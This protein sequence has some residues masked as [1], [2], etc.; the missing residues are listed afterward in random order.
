MTFSGRSLPSR[1]HGDLA[2]DAGQ[3]PVHGRSKALL[4]TASIAVA[5]AAADTYVVVLALQDMMSGVGISVDALQRAAPIISGFLLGY[6]AVLP[7][8][9]RLADLVA[10]Q[11]VL[12]AC[13]GIFVVGSA[14]TALSVDLPVMVTG[15]VVQ[16]IGGGGL[17]PATLALVADLW[18]R[19]RRGT[20]LGAVSAV[21]ELGS[22][23]GPLLGAL[24][25]MV[26]DW[27]AIFWINA[28][29]GVALALVIRVLGGGSDD[30]LTHAHPLWAVATGVCAFATV[31]LLG[32]ALVAPTA[33]TSSIRWGAPFVPYAGHSAR[34]A[35]PIGIWGLMALAV[36]LLCS[37]RYWWP[38]LRRADLLGAL[39]VAVALGAVIVTFASANPEQ[40]VVGPMG[41]WLL[42]VAAVAVL[43]AWWRHRTAADPLVGVGTVVGRVRPA[44][45]CSVCVG[46]A[47][48]AIVVD[49][50][51]L[52]RLTVTDSE[53]SAALI[54]VRFLVAVPVGALLGGWLLRHTGPGT[55]AAPG[56][57]VAA[58]GLW[59]MSAWSGHA[60]DQVSSTVELV[61]VGLGIGVAI[62]PLND[63]AL[64]DAPQDAHGMA[65]ALVVVARM[66]G[67]VVGLALLTGIGLHRFYA[68]IQSL[69]DPSAAQVEAAGVVQVQTVFAGAAIAAAVAALVALL[70]GRRRLAAEEVSPPA[71]QAAAA[72]RSLRR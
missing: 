55:V 1:H 17:V 21:Q 14:V 43:L 23:V 36:L 26:W 51:I 60:L 40:Q 39:L 34:L 4:A 62:A 22:V 61:L 13:L 45:L 12:L 42:P 68:R 67:M 38:V 64:H 28:I 2:R 25:L 63:A 47:L 65:S 58:I 44:L 53:T 29:L 31:V 24:V 15:R 33:L 16:G 3:A 35:T 72:P 54:L 9:G 5:L 49:V 20:A 18:P 27:R 10:R 32:L 8:I 37:A 46:T 59:L 6:V 30:K 48:V 71:E 66:V 7:L 11:R 19:G 41:Y 70:L 69:A 52:A 56:L 57:A 50:P